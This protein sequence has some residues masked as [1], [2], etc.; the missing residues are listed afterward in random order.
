MVKLYSI[1][2]RNRENYMPLFEDKNGRYWLG[3]TPSMMTPLLF[4]S[5][6]KAREGL[7]TILVRDPDWKNSRLVILKAKIVPYGI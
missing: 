5:K 6:K 2:E 7:A 3:G 1:F 4:A